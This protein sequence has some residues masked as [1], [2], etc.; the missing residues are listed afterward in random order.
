MFLLVALYLDILKQFIRN[1]NMWVGLKVVPI[2]LLANMFLGI[3]YNLSVWYKLGN[4]TMAGAYITVLGAAITL[5]INWLLIPYY[6]YMAC[7][8]ATFACYGS[9]MVASYIWGQKEYR[10]PYATKKLVALMV[11]VVLL[12]FIHRGIGYLY[13]PLWFRLSL[14][15]LLLGIFSWFI[16]QIERK[17]LKKLPVVGKYL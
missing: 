9:M 7:A 6:S 12:F 15:T 11:I 17:E 10:I 4:K 1:P 3:Y 5:L 13:D 16:L 2:L 14:A 8:W